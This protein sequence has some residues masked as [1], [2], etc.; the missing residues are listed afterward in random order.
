MKGYRD[1]GLYKQ[2]SLHLP[3]EKSRNQPFWDGKR[4]SESSKQ[5]MIDR[6]RKSQQLNGGNYD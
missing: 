3:K 5:A 2:K 1:V 4:Q 6:I